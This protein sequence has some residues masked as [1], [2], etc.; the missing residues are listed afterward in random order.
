MRPATSGGTSPAPSPA[1][2]E[3][4]G[5]DAAL[6]KGSGKVPFVVLFGTVVAFIV[7]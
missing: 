1:C 5:A 2:D 7:P 3:S 6:T 4:P